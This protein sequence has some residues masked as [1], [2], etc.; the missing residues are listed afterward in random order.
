MD[1]NAHVFTSSHPLVIVGLDPGTNMGQAMP[2]TAQYLVAFDLI[3]MPKTPKNGCRKEE[4]WRKLHMPEL[5][6]DSTFR[7]HM[8]PFQSLGLLGSPS[9][10]CP[11]PQ[12]GP[13]S[14]HPQS[15]STSSPIPIR[16]PIFNPPL[17]LPQPV[18]AS[19]KGNLGPAAVVANPRIKD[20]IKD[21][22]QVWPPVG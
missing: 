9:H 12:P 22:W 10:S 5:H 15:H 16:I 21:R 6:M 1:S 3:A 11:H 8:H 2:H 13:H 18:T 20:W 7:D 4:D 17:A 19:V 14:I